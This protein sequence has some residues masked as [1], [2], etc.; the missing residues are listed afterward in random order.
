MKTT[1]PVGFLIAASLVCVPARA[2][3]VV[4]EVT[5]DPATVQLRGANAVYTLLIHGS[6][7]DGRLVDGTSTAQLRPLQPKIATVNERGM[8]RGVSDGATQ[9][10]VEAAGRS[11]SVPV[12]GEASTE[13][14]RF[15]F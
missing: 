2:E 7:A 4:Q 6:R 3:E 1:F 13:A 9:V 14:R 12:K 10:S 5:V 15:N 8:I 11:P